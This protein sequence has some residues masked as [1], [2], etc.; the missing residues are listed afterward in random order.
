MRRR[1]C[2]SAEDLDGVVI[3]AEGSVLGDIVE[4][5]EVD[6]LAPELRLGVVERTV[7]RI[8][9]LGGESDDDLRL[10]A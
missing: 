4:D 5:Q 10:G 7:M 2:L 1:Q 9:G 8:S 6:T 3:V